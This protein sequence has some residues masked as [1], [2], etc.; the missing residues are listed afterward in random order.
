LPPSTARLVQLDSNMH[1]RTLLHIPPFALSGGLAAEYL[2]HRDCVWTGVVLVWVLRWATERVMQ[3]S[4]HFAQVA[5]A[6]L[7]A[8]SPEHVVVAAVAVVVRP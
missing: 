2:V 3:R 8:T 4:P 6:Q 7:E 5:Q 1:T